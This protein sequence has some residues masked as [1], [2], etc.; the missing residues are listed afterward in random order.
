MENGLTGD[1]GQSHIAAEKHVI[2]PRTPPY[3]LVSQLSDTM[4]AF[5]ICA[6]LRVPGLETPPVPGRRPG[7][8]RRFWAAPMM[9]I[10]E[11]TSDWLGW[12]CQV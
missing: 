5:D 1:G 2:Q 11:T 4:I 7:Q 12:L 10:T 8:A 3:L 9:K 6:K